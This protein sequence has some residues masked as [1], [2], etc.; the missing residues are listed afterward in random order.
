MSIGIGSTLGG[1]QAVVNLVSKLH[2]QVN[3]GTV[4]DKAHQAN[5]DDVALK[6]QLAGMF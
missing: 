5:V 4:M 1:N 3:V 6:T 2:Q